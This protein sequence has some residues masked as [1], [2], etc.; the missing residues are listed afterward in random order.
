[1]PIDKSRDDPAERAEHPESAELAPGSV[2]C[3]G[4]MIEW[5]SASVGTG[6]TAGG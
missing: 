3:L 4:T 2:I 6:K 5:V 1:V